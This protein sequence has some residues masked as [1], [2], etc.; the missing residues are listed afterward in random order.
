MAKLSAQVHE[1]REHTE[2][3]CL[4][5]VAAAHTAD[6][7]HAESSRKQDT[8]AEKVDNL[9]DVV[10]NLLRGGRGASMPGIPRAE[11]SQDFKG[12]AGPRREEG[13]SAPAPTRPSRAR[14]SLK[15]CR[16]SRRRAQ[17]SRRG[18]FAWQD[19]APDA[20]S[21]SRCRVR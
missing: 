6:T 16:A 18:P 2:R 8:L 21:S 15:Q 19:P 3:V 17:R 4:Q 1:G 20:T 14:R 9:H 11:G 10:A 13:A 5:V 12:P 7:R